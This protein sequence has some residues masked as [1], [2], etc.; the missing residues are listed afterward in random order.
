MFSKEEK[1]AKRFGGGRGGENASKIRSA[2]SRTGMPRST[3]GGGG[4]GGRTSGST[5]RESVTTTIIAIYFELKKLVVG[6][7]KP[8]LFWFWL[9]SLFLY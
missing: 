8:F 7:L 2:M 1:L 6:I 5:S 4:S 3:N 9:L